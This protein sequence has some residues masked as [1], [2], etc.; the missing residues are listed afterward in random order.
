[1][2]S[3]KT[4]VIEWIFFHL[5]YDAAT[6]SLRDPVVTGEDI[7]KGITATGVNLQTS[8]PPNFWK[9]LTRSGARGLE[10]NWPS[11]V[12]Q[13]G[14]GATD[15]IGH[16]P[17]AAFLFVQVPVGQVVPAHDFV[18]FNTHLPPH[19]LQSLSMPIAMRGLGRRS[20]NWHAQVAHRLDVVASYFALCSPRNIAPYAVNEV[21]FLQTGIKVKRAEID[22][23]FSVA[24][25][26]GAW[27]VAAE[28][29][30]KREEFYLPQVK[31]AA[32]ELEETARSGSDSMLKAI[33]G[34]IPVGIKVVGKS[35][36]WV[37]EF[38]PVKDRTAPLNKMAEGLFEL[39]PH[40]P[41]VE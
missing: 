4:P 8:N 30:G 9:D 34:V 25:N 7:E 12:S 19:K 3:L 27:L 16:G 14:Y 1:M 37:V 35:Q 15:A 24:T 2:T 33:T 17:R 40:V 26:D 28:I 38:E 39:V 20:E 6:R 41:G 31:R 23:S 32:L 29:K 10:K 5:K 11:S 21:N 13:C 18:T 22:A 36:L